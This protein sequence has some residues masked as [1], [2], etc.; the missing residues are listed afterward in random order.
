MRARIGD[1]NLEVGRC[2]SLF[3]MMRMSRGCKMTRLARLLGLMVFSIIAVAF[4][5]C[6]LTDREPTPIP[7]QVPLNQLNRW[8]NEEKASNPNVTDRMIDRDRKFTFTGTV[9]K[10]DGKGVEFAN[11]QGKCKNP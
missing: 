9:K 5:A 11:N 1:T 2:L 6:T 8:L 4:I 7:T 3:A 10:V